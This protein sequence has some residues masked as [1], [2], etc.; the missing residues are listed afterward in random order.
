MVPIANITSFRFFSVFPD[1][2]YLIIKTPEKEI[3]IFEIEFLFKSNKAIATIAN[4]IN[5]SNTQL[6]K[7]LSI[8]TIFYHKKNNKKG[9]LIHVNS[10]NNYLKNLELYMPCY[11]TVCKGV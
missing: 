3:K 11:G 7:F 1:I 10:C 5:S 4:T 6:N 8:E 9:A 2:S